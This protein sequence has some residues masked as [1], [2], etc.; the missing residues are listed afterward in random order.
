MSTIKEQLLKL[1]AAELE[2]RKASLRDFL[3]YHGECDDKE[4]AQT[5]ADLLGQNWITID[6][7]DYV[8]SQIIDNK[9]KPLINKQAR[10]MFSRKPDIFLKA[11]DNANADAVHELNQ[12]INMILDANKFWS[13]TMKA[14]RLA[15]VTKRVMLRLEANPNMPVRLYWHGINDFTYEVDPNDPSNLTKV[16][17]VKQDPNTMGKILEHQRWF[18]YTYFIEGGQ[19]NL[20]TEV[21][22]GNQL[23]S[24]IESKTILTK[25]TRIPCWVVCNEQSIGESH[26]V[27][28]LK[29]LRPLQDQ[30]NRK[31][32][33]FSDALRFNMFGQDVFIDAT[34]ET[35]NNVKV[36]PNSVVA[37][38][39]LDDKKADYK[40]VENTFS[41]A[42]PVKMFLDTL[43]D[44]MYEKL[45]IPKPE[46]MRTIVSG[47]AFKYMFT[48]LMARCD[49]KWIDWEP[50]FVQLVQMIVESCSK[51]NC[52]GD[53][54]KEWGSLSYNVIIKRNYPIPED[55]EDKKRLAMEEVSANVRSRRSYIK[56][57][58]DDE[59]YEALFTEVCEDLAKITAAEN[60]LFN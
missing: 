51:F 14:F 39:S 28:D 54:Q 12:Y 47:K 8:P 18:R 15:T 38:V 5:N 52:Y 59:T 10:F 21:F 23:D 27:S 48:E 36:A 35:V 26:G 17:L 53:W 49:E 13:E 29:D 40:K 57:F 7:L 30:Y 2:E 37:L 3:F 25:L 20:M 55:V 46:E 50:V 24:P 19:C 34:A 11:Y 56:E 41:N 43:N 58:S 6:D 60:E 44:S 1:D 45:A 4:V 42:T 16:I 32:S 33:D 31:L 9:I 22:N